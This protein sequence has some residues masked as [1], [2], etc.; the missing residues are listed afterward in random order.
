M[1]PQRSK[2]NLRMEKKKPMKSV[3]TGFPAGFL[4][5]GA[6]AAN[7][8]EGAWNVE[9]KGVSIADIE[10]LPEVY[11]RQKVVGFR[12]THDEIAAAAQ[13]ETKDYPRRRGIDFYHTYKQDLALLKEM[14]FTCFRTSFNWTRIFPNG[15]E[16]EP[17]EAGLRFYDDLID[18]ML[19]LGIRRS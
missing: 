17:N 5:G 9:G 18:E 16:T 8:C 14:G 12:H 4:W 10:E 6:V 7:Q 13:D 1:M 11:S 15:D 19:R 2:W 3:P